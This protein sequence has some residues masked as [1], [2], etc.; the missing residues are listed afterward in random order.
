MGIHA[1]VIELPNANIFLLDSGKKGILGEVQLDWLA[2]Q[3]DKH[4]QR[5]ALVFG[6]FNPLP[7]RGVRPSRGM[8]EGRALLK[9]LAQRKHAK[10]YIHGHT[11]DWQHSEEEHCPDNWATP[12][13][14]LFWERRCLW[15]D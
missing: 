10:A 3:L 5:P 1:D 11:H 9:L 15:M 8:P 4:T 7:T 6:H 14:L 2:Q 13:Q 12:R